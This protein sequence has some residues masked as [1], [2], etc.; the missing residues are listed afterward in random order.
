MAAEDGAAPVPA[1]PTAASIAA[2]SAAE[3]FARE[4]KAFTEGRILNRRVAWDSRQGLRQDASETA[5]S[6]TSTSIPWLPHGDSDSG[7]SDAAF[8]GHAILRK[9]NLL[10]T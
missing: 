3:P 2:T 6:C 7:H 4:A 8:Q 9:L 1:G 5:C 10:M